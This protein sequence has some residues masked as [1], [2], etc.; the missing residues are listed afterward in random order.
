ML[1]LERPNGIGH[2]ESGLGYQ[3]A[4]HP[5]VLPVLRFAFAERVDTA[6]QPHGTPEP[7]HDEQ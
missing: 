1:R 3:V 6:A 5:H 4:W 2:I 7:W